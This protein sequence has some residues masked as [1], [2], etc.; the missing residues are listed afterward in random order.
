MLGWLTHVEM[1]HRHPLLGGFLADLAQRGR[2]ILFDKR[3]SGLSDRTQDA[4]SPETRVADLVTV[5]DAAESQRPIV[6]GVSEGASI[7]ALFA[8]EHPARTRGLFAFGATAKL[9]ASDD[10]PHG[11]PASFIEHL[12][13]EVE[14]NWGEPVFVDL[15]TPSMKGD[16]EFGEWLA[17][18]MR[19]AASP[20]AALEMLLAHVAL[21][22]RPA[23]PRIACPTTIMHR[24]GDRVIP[25]DD[26]RWLAQQIPG[27]ELVV[28]EGVDHLP[29]VGDKSAVLHE[30]DRLI[31]RIG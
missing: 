31:A 29:F 9:L 8:A 3:G 17:T 18:Y 27:A 16:A 22:I 26:G 30:I 19:S 1:S 25:V 6:F 28:T 10:Y 7:G 24:A 23:L 20:S 14:E 2:V 5:L 13:R 4:V 11:Q 12:T 15:E 21:D